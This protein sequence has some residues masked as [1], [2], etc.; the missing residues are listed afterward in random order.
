MA[1]S[2]KLKKGGEARYVVQGATNNDF[3][4]VPRGFHVRYLAVENLANLATSGTISVGKVPATYTT[5]TFA[6]T[7]AITTS[8]QTFTWGGG[9]S[10]T[11][12]TT[13]ASATGATL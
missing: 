1:L 7:T 10:G 6:V 13:T 4:T 3:F 8:A 12:L 5:A 9:A 2:K 11:F